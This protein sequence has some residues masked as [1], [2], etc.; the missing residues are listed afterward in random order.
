MLISKNEQLLEEKKLDETLSTIKQKISSLGTEL[1]DD[2]EKILEFKK[3]LWDSHAEMDPAEMKI[4]MSNN[5]VE[6]SI[7]MSKGAYLQK[8]Y[9][10]Q[11]KPYFGSIIF[12]NK[13]DAPQNIYIGITHIENNLNY[14][15][16]DWR[17]PICRL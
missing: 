13:E 16:Y 8:L 3:F 15:V 7:M 17:S 10:I 4:M 2:E 11:N 1:Y 6:I 5:D 14:Y 12:D 9:K